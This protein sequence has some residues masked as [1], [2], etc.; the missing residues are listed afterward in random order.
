M[1]RL[2]LPPGNPFFGEAGHDAPLAYYYLWHFS[3]AELALIPGVSGWEADIA[4]SAFTAFSS[5]ALMMGFAA[6]IGG[7]AAAGRLGGT[8][9]LCRFAASGRR[10]ASLARRISTPTFLPPT[11]FAGWLFQTTWAPQ[12]TASTSCVLLSSVLLLQ[13]ARRPS[14]LTLVVLALA[15]SPATKA[16]P[17]SAALCLPWP[18]R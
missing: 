15:S 17:G 3:A 13:L 7:R 5:V 12:H 9:C 11:G 6:W 4:L 10:G 18:R 2:G 1:T 16:R 14:L 8:S